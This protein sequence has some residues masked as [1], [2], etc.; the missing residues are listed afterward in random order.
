MKNPISVY[1]FT[2]IPSISVKIR[3]PAKCYISSIYIYAP[4]YTVWKTTAST[5]CFCTARAFLCIKNK[6]CLFHTACK[7]DCFTVDILVPSGLAKPSHGKQFPNST[8]IFKVKTTLPL[9]QIE[10]FVPWFF[11]TNLFATHRSFVPYNP[12]HNN[13]WLF[14]VAVCSLDFCQVFSKWYSC[15]IGEGGIEPHSSVML[16]EG[17]DSQQEI[18]KEKKNQTDICTYFFCLF[19]S[20]M[21]TK[22]LRKNW[23][24]KN[25][26]LHDANSHS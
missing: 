12:A 9:L 22:I 23:K 10:L 5:K 3:Y 2:L 13:A 20:G 26:L 21:W 19:V 6:S 18:Q 1:T 16:L 8:L 17:W 11:M 14:T 4:Q 25:R 7:Y 15:S 24:T